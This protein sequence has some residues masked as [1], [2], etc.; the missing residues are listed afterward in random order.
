MEGNKLSFTKRRVRGRGVARVKGRKSLIEQAD[1][2]DP[3]V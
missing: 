2:C 1:I 3:M